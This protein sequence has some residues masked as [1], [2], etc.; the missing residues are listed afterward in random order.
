MAG[1]TDVG[2]TVEQYGLV[3]LLGGVAG[4]YGHASKSA[5]SECCTKSTLTSLA[6][7]L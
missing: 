5:D 1:A 2:R 7:R 3:R 4:H 6:Y